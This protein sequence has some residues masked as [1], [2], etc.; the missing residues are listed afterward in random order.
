LRQIGE[1]ASEMIKVIEDILS[2]SG[3]D[4]DFIKVE[5]PTTPDP[6]EIDRILE[7]WSEERGRII[8]CLLLLDRVRRLLS[9]MLAAGRLT[10]H[11]IADFT[12]MNIIRLSLFISLAS[13]CKIFIYASYKS[14]RFAIRRLAMVLR[15]YRN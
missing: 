1:G 4:G 8:E 10:D 5:I 2:M 12:Y 3:G 6:D 11:D 15:S 13:L 14:L 9:R 7:A